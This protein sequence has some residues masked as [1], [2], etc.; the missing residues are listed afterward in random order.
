[1][2]VIKQNLSVITI[3]TRQNFP[4]R[5]Q[6][7]VTLDFKSPALFKTKTKHG[8]CPKQSDK[9]FKNEELNKGIQSKYKENK[10]G[11]IKIK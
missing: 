1:M 2:K 8:T 10:G 9:E 5:G 3:E 7:T 4:V 11:N 6:V